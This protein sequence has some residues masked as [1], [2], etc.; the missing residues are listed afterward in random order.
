M[1]ISLGVYD[2]YAYIIPGLLYLFVTNELFR[3]VG[4]RFVDVGIWFQPGQ[5]PGIIFAIAILLLAYL[6]GHM[7]DIVAYQFYLILRYRLRHKEG[8][9]DHQL[10]YLRKRYPY[11][12]IQ[13]NPKDWNTLFTLLRERNN[14]IAKVI[15]KY[16]ADSI[17]LRNI[18][19]SM[20]LFAI[21]QVALFFTTGLWENLSVAMVSFLISSLS[22]NKS[23]R[24]RAWSYTTIFE[25]S[26]GYGKTLKEVVEYTH[27][28]DFVEKT[29]KVA[30]KIKAKKKATD[31]QR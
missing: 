24:F 30:G 21:M 27:G 7:L 8:V 20:F 9:S 14:D 31:L 18:A 6:V 1:S 5:A 19:F 12:D 29:T 10:N 22:M 16:Q 23:N 25:A 28:K 11:L 15:D 13:Y 3:N 26:L 17:M 2:F 4:W